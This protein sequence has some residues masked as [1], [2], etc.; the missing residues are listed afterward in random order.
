MAD[1]NFNRNEAEQSKLRCPACSSLVKLPADTCNHCGANMRTG[2]VVEEDDGGGRRKLILGL[3]ALVL[4]L[5]LAA[6]FFGLGSGQKAAPAAQGPQQDNSLSSALESVQD[7]I[8]ERPVF[9][10]GPVLDQTRNIADQAG[11]KSRRVDEPA[12]DE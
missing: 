3:L 6:L 7:T 11:Q 5:G 1:A 4:V 10:Y 2:F 12:A 8:N 9:N